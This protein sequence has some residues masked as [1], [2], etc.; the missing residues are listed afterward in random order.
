MDI[1]SV[2]ET[3]VSAGYDIHPQPAAARTL[4]PMA[5]ASAAVEGQPAQSDE[6]TK[7]MVEDIQK[8]MGNM[9][10]CLCFD[11]YGANDDQVCIVLKEKE[12]GKVIREIPS[13]ELQ[14][15]YTK[16][17]EWVGMVLNKQA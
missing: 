7:Q 11:T 6:R 15:L 10:I 14:S 13:K 9:D 5:A 4:Q 12:T 17:Q 8:N 2:S 3:V 16:M 1:N